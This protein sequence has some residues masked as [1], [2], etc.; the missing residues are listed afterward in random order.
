[1]FATKNINLA[2]N[3]GDLLSFLPILLTL[4]FFSLYWFVA[5]SEKIK[6]K[7]YHS[8]PSDKDLFNHIF[9]TKIF[10]FIS[11][12]IFPLLI[13]LIVFKDKSLADFGLSFNQDT[14]VFTISWT[15]GLSILVIP[16]AHFSAKK[17][18]N[19]KNYPQAR[20]KIW[21]KSMRIKEAFAWFAYLFGYELLFRGVLLFP[22]VEAFGVWPA[23]AI[24]IALY[25]A[26]HIP[27]GLD[28]TIGAVPLGLVLC[29][30]TLLSGDIWIA[31]LVHVAMAWTN[32]FTA[33]HFHPE[34]EYEENMK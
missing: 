6:S 30:L 14:L 3:E 10:G 9:F 13:C 29:I 26:T 25:A 27:K 21:S 2:W 19:L 1:M 22:L 5:Q 8:N 34:M 17:P 20:S 12:G 28:E 24:N 31:F 4:I 15:L 16:I 32:T 18:K 11:M 23:I 7:F 33:L